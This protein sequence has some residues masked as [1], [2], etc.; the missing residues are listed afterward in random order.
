MAQDEAGRSFAERYAAKRSKSDEE[1]SDWI[2]GRGQIV[3]AG[4]FI[5]I[6]FWLIVT[7]VIG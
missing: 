5:A 7:L 2:N 3:I 1:V 4:V 6:G